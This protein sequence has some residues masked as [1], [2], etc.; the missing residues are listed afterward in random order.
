MLEENESELS[1]WRHEQSLQVEILRISNASFVEDL[2]KHQLFES[3]FAS[4]SDN[5][6]LDIETSPNDT[7]KSNIEL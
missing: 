2:D 3:L 5:I 4:N 7:N 6:V 1:T